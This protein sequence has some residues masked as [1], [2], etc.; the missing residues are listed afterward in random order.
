MKML[1]RMKCHLLKILFVFIS[2]HFVKAQ[3]ITVI[4]SD[5]N[6]PL[7]GIA[8]YNLKKTKSLVTNLEGKVDIDIF[9]DSET[10]FFQNFLFFLVTVRE[11]R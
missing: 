1:L 4:E 11:P 8:I 7:P 6:D 10:I 5:T 9:D 2:I 3:T